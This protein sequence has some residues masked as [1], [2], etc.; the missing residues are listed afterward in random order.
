M[1]GA[2]IIAFDDDDLELKAGLILARARLD[3][4]RN[5]Q[6]RPDGA[7]QSDHAQAGIRR[8]G[9]GLA[10]GVRQL[11][12]GLVMICAAGMGLHALP[13]LTEFVITGGVNGATVGTFDGGGATLTSISDLADTSAADRQ[14]VAQYFKPTVSGSYSF[15]LSKSNEDTVL[16]LYSGTFN[17]SSPSTNALSLNDDPTPPYGAG[18]VVMEACG[19]QISYCPRITTNLTANTTYHIV[20]TSYAP[21]MTVSDGVKFYIYGEPVTVGATIEEEEAEAAKIVAAPVKVAR[22]VKTQTKI[23]MA[24]MSN[25]DSRFLR[26]ARTRH[27][28]QQQLAADSAAAKPVSGKGPAASMTPA[29]SDFRLAGSMDDHGHAFSGGMTSSV[30][31]G[32]SDANIVIFGDFVHT[33]DRGVSDTEQVNAKIALEQPMGPHTTG[34]GFVGASAGGGKIRG[35]TPGDHDF[36]SVSVGAYAVHSPSERFHVAGVAS[37]SL[38]RNKMKLKDGADDLRSTFDINT[39]SIGLNATG[40]AKIYRVKRLRLSSDRYADWP[41]GSSNHLI[42]DTRDIELWPT[43]MLDYSRSEFDNDG[44]SLVSG[45]V[46]TAITP[47]VKDSSRLTLRASPEL[48][49]NIERLNS[50]LPGN[51]LTL[52]PSVICEWTRAERDTSECGLGFGLNLTDRTGANRLLKF[53]LQNVETRRDMA[54][55][56]QLSIPF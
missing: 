35:A 17:P 54:A 45:G 26:D 52:A 5:N 30:R 49:F 44:S 47:I 18:G 19:A 12:T 22:V 56:L 48:K 43:F 53:E 41:D 27:I 29:P 9:L 1:P 51:K 39:A 37:V 33:R 20:I 4:V 11:I 21:N 32:N 8:G 36:S 50:T 28:R 7:A 25:F 34:G 15:G 3:A 38:T 40:L 10:R 46:T 13:V 2:E 14:Y 6:N 24:K 42:E 16:I 23:I 55:S 31:A